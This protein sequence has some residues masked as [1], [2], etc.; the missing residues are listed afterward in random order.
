MSMLT[1]LL[2][3][4]SSFAVTTSTRSNIRIS[5]EDTTDLGLVDYDANDVVFCSNW[6]FQSDSD[7]LNVKRVTASISPIA[8]GAFYRNAVYLRNPCNR[9]AEIELKD[10]RM[11]V[12]QTQ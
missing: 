9:Q 5:I 1:I 2:F 10:Q 6:N 7:D 11:L 3:S 12:E 8:A 4:F